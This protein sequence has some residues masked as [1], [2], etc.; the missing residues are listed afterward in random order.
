MSSRQDGTAGGWKATKEDTEVRGEEAEQM[1]QG[2]LSHGKEL[3]LYS[4]C[5]VKQMKCT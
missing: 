5:E 2:L 3:G 4:L 1:V